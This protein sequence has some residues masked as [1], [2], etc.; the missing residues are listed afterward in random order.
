MAMKRIVLISRRPEVKLW[1]RALFKA[2]FVV[3]ALLV[4]GILSAIVKPGSFANFYKYTINGTFASPKTFV[5]LLWETGILFI[6]AV[7]LT[8]AFKMKF[9]NIGAEGQV[10]T[11]DGNK[12]YWGDGGTQID[13]NNYWT[14]VDGTSIPLQAD[15]NSYTTI[16]NYYS[17]ATNVTNTAD[18]IINTPYEGDNTVTNYGFTLKVSASL[19]AN[20]SNITNI[21]QD[22]YP[23]NQPIHYT[24]VTLDGGQVWTT[25]EQTALISQVVQKTG[26]TMTGSLN[27][28]IDQDADTPAINFI[29]QAT[30]GAPDNYADWRIQNSS[31][32][33]AGALTI[34]G[35]ANT[36]NGYQ[37]RAWFEVMDPSQTGGSVTG[38]FV[39]DNV[40]LRNTP[41]NP[42]GTGLNSNGVF[43]PIIQAS[44]SSTI[45]P[46]NI[47]ELKA[48]TP[49]LQVS[50]VEGTIQGPVVNVVLNSLSA[51]AV[52]PVASSSY[53][54]VISTTKQYFKGHKISTSNVSVGKLE[55]IGGTTAGC[56]A[57][58]AGSIYLSG[59]APSL[60]FKHGNTSAT[61]TKITT[62]A[63]DALQATPRLLIGSQALGA[64][65]IAQNEGSSNTYSCVINNAESNGLFVHGRTTIDQ[66]E[67]FLYENYST[68][69]TNVS[70]IPLYNRGHLLS[71]IRYAKDTY[72]ETA[73]Q[74]TTALIELRLGNNITTTSSQASDNARGVITLYN[75]N[76][77]TGSSLIGKREILGSTT[78][79]YIEA[80][81]FKGTQIWGAVW[82][83]YAEFRETKET[84]EPGR[85]IIETGNGDLILSTTRLQNGA[86]I[87][88]DT[89]GFAI[90]Q[91]KKCNTPIASNGRVLAY[92]YEDTEDAR[93]HIGQP[94][95]S[96]PNGTVS[97]M[98]NQE[99][100]DYPW[101][102]IGT[103]S[104][105]PNYDK[106]QVGNLEQ[107]EFI[108][109]NGR[110]WI[111]VR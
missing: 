67:L 74:D 32:A 88:S 54:G 4:C 34:F 82:N 14:L 100:R 94:V 64:S 9:W 49:N 59:A 60:V 79:N 16:G 105:I 98:T 85:C 65:A 72:T 26:D 99:A 8:P 13:V 2:I 101:K 107:D 81:Y 17:T 15:L 110:I 29:R 48:I 52:T 76:S 38:T 33:A 47:G 19:G 70:I 20:N 73:K 25:W 90:G 37:A 53:S 45:S 108:N 61:S 106:W 50:W 87:V 51:T 109:V 27:L 111:R 22:F 75:N 102:I 103:I 95:C 55:I 12:V 39:V 68:T 57:T 77:T 44:T 66:G 7:A 6:I 69:N 36:S 80:D 42:S 86:E 5:K 41:T 28:V 78:Q 24:R 104:E 30:Q 10:L 3:I 35:R 56:L 83:D 46:S 31:S 18:R 97:I 23:Y 58:T 21:R 40:K 96:G 71:E 93:K 1:K 89:Y 84:I 62:R 43:L 92:L 63:P 91:S 11:T